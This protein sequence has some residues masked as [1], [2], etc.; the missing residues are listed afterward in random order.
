[1]PDNQR[2]LKRVINVSILPKVK[3][4]YCEHD[5]FDQVCRLRYL[6][7]I[8]SGSGKPVLITEVVY[9]CRGCGFVSTGDELLSNHI[10]SGQS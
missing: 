9:L 3:C 4:K 2:N 8:Q 6:S 1:M 5:I 7:G 10:K